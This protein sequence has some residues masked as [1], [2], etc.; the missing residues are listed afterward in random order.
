VGS[1]KIQPETKGPAQPTPPQASP[2]A[3]P[4]PQTEAAPAEKELLTQKAPSVVKVPKKKVKKKA[5]EPKKK[6]QPKPKTKTPPTPKQEPKAQPKPTP[7]APKAPPRTYKGN[8]GS[9]NN[10]SS[11]EGNDAVPG[12]KGDPSGQ[13][14][15]GAYSGTNSGLGKSGVGYSLAGRKMVQ[16]PT[17]NDNSNTVGKITVKITV[18]QNGKVINA[19]IGKPTTISKPS[20]V[21][22]SIQAAYRAKFN[23]NRDAA[24]EQFGTITF[25]YKVN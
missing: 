1:G 20:L 11:G 7:P 5:T 4:E 17:V 2:P 9:K 25:V 14:G 15:P 21:Q 19:K 23:A 8:G 13:P 18:D 16:A 24:E 3:Q 22:K 12:D 6:A 10:S